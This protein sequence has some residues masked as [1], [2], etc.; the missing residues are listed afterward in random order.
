MMGKI[1]EGTLT[2]YEIKLV[3]CV[4]CNPPKR[5][6]ICGDYIDP[7]D[8]LDLVETYIVLRKQVDRFVAQII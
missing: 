2:A 3:H 4:K 5:C 7:M 6:G 1:N 8:L